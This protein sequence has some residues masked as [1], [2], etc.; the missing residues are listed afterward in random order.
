M[1]DVIGIIFAGVSVIYEGQRLKE[2]ET[3]LNIEINLELNI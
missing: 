1:A 2:L 3:L